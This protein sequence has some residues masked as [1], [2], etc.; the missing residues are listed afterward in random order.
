MFCPECRAEY[1]EGFTSC[2][3]C[4][5]TLVDKL[6]DKPNATAKPRSVFVS[7]A[8]DTFWP[9]VT[10]E[11]SA[12]RAARSGFWMAVWLAAVNTGVPLLS[13][14][15][16]ILRPNVSRIFL[17]SL[18]DGIAFTV[19]AWGIH[20]LYR[21]AAIAALCLYLAERIDMWTTVGP[22]NP[23]VAFFF[24]VCFI[25]AVR[26]TFAFHRLPRQRGFAQIFG[27]SPESSNILEC[28][29][30]RTV[31]PKT[32]VRCDCGYMFNSTDASHP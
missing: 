3:S 14:A 21:T 8:L 28:P 20:K 10:D 29:M 9:T 30:C 13:V 23:V 25:N 6:P 5:M 12:K 1:R 17:D 32:A 26:G 11:D 2:A 18:G 22:K 19:I 15:V 27:R 7:R 4:G 16:N 24:T 31:N